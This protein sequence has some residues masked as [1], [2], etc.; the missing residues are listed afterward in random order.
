MS[1]SFCVL[2]SGSAGNCTLLQ[3]GDPDHA[4]H[5][6][7]TP[8]KPGQVLID[9]GLSPRA[10]AKALHA[11]GC[12][13]TDL[14]AVL[15]T[16]LDSDHFHGGWVKV[17]RE[18]RI[19]A[20]LLLHHRHRNVA[21]SMGLNVDCVV[22]FNDFLTIDGTIVHPIML[23]HDALGSVG[24]V[25]EHAGLRLGYATDFGRASEGLLDR[26]TNLHALAIESNYD[27]RMQQ[28]S[29]RPSFLK[30]RIMGGAGHLSNEQ[31]LEAVLEIEGGSALSHL[32]LLHLS[33]ECNCPNLVRDLYARRAPHLV[34]RL[35]VSSQTAVTP[36]LAIRPGPLG[37]HGLHGLHG[38]HESHGR[39][40]SMIEPKWRQQQLR[41]FAAG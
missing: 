13:L 10:T 39:I 24:Y 25:I 30:H 27:R 6:A 18:R 11:F 23:S 21:W 41:L 22:L 19:P 3:L 33:R 15:L 36:T 2:A 29:S 16:H 9:A 14:R 26:F 5:H 34:D 1:F 40:D 12:R 38:S 17:F 28:E 37:L 8:A 20:T 32:A 31:C 7:G 4:L 35:T